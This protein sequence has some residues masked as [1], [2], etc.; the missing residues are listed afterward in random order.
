LVPEPP[1]TLAAGDVVTIGIA[2]LGQLTNPVVRGRA[3]MMW[4]TTAGTGSRGTAASTLRDED[5]GI[6]RR[7]DGRVTVAAGRRSRP[8]GASQHE[9]EHPE[10]R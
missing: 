8:A 9:P 7:N 3:D 10:Q 6:P 2:G 1:F 5:P 4:V